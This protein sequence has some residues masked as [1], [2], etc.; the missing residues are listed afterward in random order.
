MLGHEMATLTLD[1]G[2]L[3]PDNLDAVAVGSDAGA[4]TTAD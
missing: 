2:H 1:L 3:F 4:R